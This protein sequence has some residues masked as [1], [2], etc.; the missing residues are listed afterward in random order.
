MGCTDKSW[1]DESTLCW[2]DAIKQQIPCKEAALKIGVDPQ[3]PG[4]PT[5]APAAT[6]LFESYAWGTRK[7]CHK[8][9]RASVDWGDLGLGVSQEM[10]F[11]ACRLSKSCKYVSFEPESGTCTSFTACSKKQRVTGQATWE[12]VT[13]TPSPECKDTNSKK[14]CTMKNEQGKCTK[15]FVARKCERTCGLC[16]RRRLQL[17]RSERKTF[18]FV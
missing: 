1:C 18:E 7:R 2:D 10:C 5:P 4:S 12:T 13:I 3:C 11:M 9:Y 8:K 15:P 17:A 6:V 14:W 16:D